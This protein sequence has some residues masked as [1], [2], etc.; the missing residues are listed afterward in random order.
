MAK[1]KRKNS[2]DEKIELVNSFMTTPFCVVEGD[3]GYG[4]LV[5]NEKDEKSLLEK[6]RI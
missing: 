4:L 2:D 5:S 3:E 6:V 1:S